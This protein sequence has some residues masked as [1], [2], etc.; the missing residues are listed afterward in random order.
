MNCLLCT[1]QFSGVFVSL[2]SLYTVKTPISRSVANFPS[3]QTLARVLTK[4]LMS[5]WQSGL[6][7]H[8]YE[9]LISTYGG[10]EKLVQDS[11]NCIY[12]SILQ[13][14]GE[15]LTAQR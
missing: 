15:D 7:G 4:S 1:A 8:D 3:L 13:L 10:G 12:S 11:L 14:E 5:R 2:S 6:D 9:V